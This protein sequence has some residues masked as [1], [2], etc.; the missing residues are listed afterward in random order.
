MRRVQNRRIVPGQPS[1]ILAI[2]AE[3]LGSLG[4]VAEMPAQ[5]PSRSLIANM[6]ERRRPLRKHR[7]QRS[8]RFRQL[9][10]RSGP[11]AL[12]RHEILLI[13]GIDDTCGFTRRP[14]ANDTKL[15]FAQR[16][17]QPRTPL[18][19]APQ[20]RGLEPRRHRAIQLRA[21]PQNAT[22]S[23]LPAAHWISLVQQPPS[24]TTPRAQLLAVEQLQRPRPPATARAKKIT[25]R[26]AVPEPHQRHADSLLDVA[27]ADNELGR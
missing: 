9:G 4:D 19:L 14:P 12:R 24:T 6:R 2:N 5:R 7:H 26:S 17:L 22:L 11:G 13:A 1:Q 21:K 18:Q 20:R 3:F 23:T 10:L 15:R 27:E 8:I 16:R 25:P